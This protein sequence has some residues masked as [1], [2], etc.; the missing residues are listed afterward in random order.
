MLGP[1]DPYKAGPIVH[2]VIRPNSGTNILTTSPYIYIIIYILYI[3][4]LQVLL[5]T[6]GGILMKPSG[7]LWVIP[8]VG[9]AERKA[10]EEAKTREAEAEAFRRFLRDKPSK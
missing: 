9:Q 2:G 5:F 8:W 3:F 6:F 4:F 1:Q 7:F 10:A